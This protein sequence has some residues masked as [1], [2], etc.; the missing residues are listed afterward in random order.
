MYNKFIKSKEPFFI[1]IFIFIVSCKKE[2]VPKAINAGFIDNTLNV[3]QLDSTQ[4]HIITFYC[5]GCPDSFYKGYADIDLDGQNDLYIG[6]DIST[7]S[8]YLDVHSLNRNLVIAAS[9]PKE[10]SGVDAPLLPLPYNIPINENQIWKGHTSF[11]DVGSSRYGF[12]AKSFYKKYIALK[13]LDTGKL[14]F[15]EVSYEETQIQG[16]PTYIITFYYCA[17]QK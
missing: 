4:R 17:F 5:Y 12:R 14:G 1:L 11:I 10:N 15:I 9:L 7:I 3:Y 16:D 6:Y 13:K 2:P 8:E